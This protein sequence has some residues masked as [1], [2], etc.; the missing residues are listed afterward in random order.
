M[1]RAVGA[2]LS[3]P[4]AGSG[5]AGAPWAL[6]ILAVSALLAGCAPDLPEAAAAGEPWPPGALAAPDAGAAAGAA[7]GAFPTGG[8]AAQAGAAAASGVQAGAADEVRAE[9]RFLGGSAAELDAGLMQLNVAMRGGREARAL[10]ERYARCVAIGYG[11][12]H[13]F[14]FARHVRTKLDFRSGIWRADAVYT[15]SRNVPAGMNLI[16]IQI[17]QQDCTNRGIPMA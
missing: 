10:A 15:M 8:E 13:G 9:G 3:L 12:R 7:G 5:R 6:P 1:P 16:D 17:E 2:M 11:L 4:L 14:A